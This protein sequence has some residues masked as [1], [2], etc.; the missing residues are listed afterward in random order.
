MMDFLSILPLSGTP[1]GTALCVCIV[2]TAIGWL[3]SLVTREC[4]WLDRIWSLCPP[5]YCL[6]VAG[7]MGFASSRVNLMT[8][9][10][11][12]WG[13]R[14]THNLARKGG[15]RRGGE[16][17]RWAVVRERAGPVGFQL[18][19]ITFIA[20]GQ[21]LIIWL[22]TALIHLA[23][24]HRDVPLGGL[25]VVAAAAF[26]ALFA[27]EAIA[28][29]QMWAF[30]QDKKRRLAAGEEIAEPFLRKG[31][32]RLSRHPGYA[33]EVGMWCVFYL[34]SVA[35]SGDWLNWTGIGVI[36]LAALLIGSIRITESI[37]ASKYAG[38]AAYKSAT[39]MLI[40]SPRLLVGRSYGTDLSGP[41]PD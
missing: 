6:I 34:F 3:W 27:V 7:M 12:L 32:F 41:A 14:L 35:A 36:G 40:P 24:L 1:F 15:Y 28:D 18:L 17:Y 8:A 30:Q 33:A 13:A 22:Y 19:N 31:L 23:W 20:P 11:C 21:M 29:G 9:L 38:Y 16:D 10:V 25:D 2:L 26:L 37:S 5:A 39:P 4:V